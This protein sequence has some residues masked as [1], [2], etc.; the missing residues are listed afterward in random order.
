[1]KKIRQQYPDLPPPEYRKPHSKRM[2]KLDIDDDS[3]GEIDRYLT[4]NLNNGLSMEENVKKVIDKV[5]KNSD[6]STDFESYDISVIEFAI[7][8]SFLADCMTKEIEGFKT[9]NY[10]ELKALDK[11]KFGGNFKS[12]FP[13]FFNVKY[14]HPDYKNN[15]ILF[16]TRIYRGDNGVVNYELNISFES[17]VP[18]KI[19]FNIYNTFQ[20][21]AFNHS[22]YKGKCLEVKIDEGN[23]SGIKIIPTDNFKTDIILTDMQKKFYEHFVKRILRG[24]QSRYLLNGIPGTGKTEMIRKIIKNVVPN[25]TFIIP[26][27]TNINDL[28]TIL[29][30]CEVFEPGIIVIDD[31]D[32]YLGDRD[33]GSH[34]GL[35][36]DFLTYFDGVKKR[37]ISILASTNNKN[38]LDKA[39]ERPGRFNIILD[40]S[41]LEDEQINEV[42]DMYLPKKW[43]KKEI[44]ETLKGN[45]NKGVKIKISGAFIA[46][47]AENIIEMSKDNKD[48][49]L[50]DTLLLIKESYAGFYNS[51]MSKEKKLGFNI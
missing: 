31:I 5:F 51:Q 27:F 44:Y 9:I 30:S 6:L 19:G 20:K 45:D 14:N 1:M 46:N 38:L 32:I 36:A 35:L 4:E 22:E 34:S 41:Y 8:N 47:L 50:D 40:F 43:R 2:L 48:W 33:R 49:S 12:N 37:N 26:D 42:V 15:T 28:K 21:V 24:N 3:E 13:W 39:A 17:A 10:G 7:Y 11:I 25:A 23:F 29:E 16:Q 18:Y